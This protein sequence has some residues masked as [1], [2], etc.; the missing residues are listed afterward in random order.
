MTHIQSYGHSI[1]H[2]KAT[3]NDLTSIGGGTYWAGRAATA[4]RPLCAP[5]E[6][7]MMFALPL[8]ALLKF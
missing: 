3:V 1:K 5:S 7:D 2:S 8:F 6:K 4:A